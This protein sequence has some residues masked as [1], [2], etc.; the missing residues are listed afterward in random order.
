MFHLP[1]PEIIFNQHTLLL[2]ATGRWVMELNLL[3]FIRVRSTHPNG[4]NVHKAAMSA[5]FPSSSHPNAPEC[6]AAEG[7][8]AC[9]ASSF[10]LC[11]PFSLRYTYTL[12]SVCALLH[13]TEFQCRRKYGN[14]IT[15]PSFPTV[16]MVLELCMWL[17]F[18]C[19]LWLYFRK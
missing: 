10:L 6:S 15:F 12:P 3:K 18:P 7:H 16:C 19:Q 13:L 1:S 9:H 2:P 5:K 8:A 14:T 11:F 17:H 4:R